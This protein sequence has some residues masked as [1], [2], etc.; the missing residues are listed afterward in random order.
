MNKKSTTPIHK[1]FAD[2]GTS[3]HP[4]VPSRDLSGNVRGAVAYRFGVLRFRA[5]ERV[6][7]SVAHLYYHSEYPY[8]DLGV[9]LFSE[10]AP[11]VQK[12]SD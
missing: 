8:A 10:L 2:C 1:P 7:E 11:A 3:D 5:L 6:Q 4:T 9:P 12:N